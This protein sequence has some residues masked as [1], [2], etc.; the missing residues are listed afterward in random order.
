MVLFSL[1]F[2][3]LFKVLRIQGL[4]IYETIV[5]RKEIQEI[6]FWWESLARVLR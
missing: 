6:P 3:S 4:R 2:F 1:S 5:R